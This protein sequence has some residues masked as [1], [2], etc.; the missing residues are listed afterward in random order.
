MS[1]DPMT[2]ADHS[3]L[4]SPVESPVESPVAQ[5]REIDALIAKA[6]GAHQAGQLH[7]A[8]AIYQDVLTLAPDHGDTLAFSGIIQCQM[9]NIEQGIHGLE[10][11]VAINPDHLVAQFNLAHAYESA[12]RFDAA[13]GAYRRVISLKPDLPDAHHHLAAVLDKLGKSRE[14]EQATCTALLAKPENSK[15]FYALIQRQ[16]KNGHLEDALDTCEKFFKAYPRNMHALAFKAFIL[17]ELGDIDA[18]RELL[19]FDRLIIC[20]RHHDVPGYETNK[21][22]NADLAEFALSHP[23]LEFEPGGKSTQAGS[24]TATIQDETAKP[25][26][27]LRQLIE[28][29]LDGYC[30]AFADHPAHPYLDSM[31]SQIALDIWA[32]VLRPEGQQKPH[33]HPG[34]W[35][36]GVYYPLLPAAMSSNGDTPAG[37]IEFGRP[38]DHFGFK[39]EPLI[40]SLQPEEGLMVLFPSYFYHRTIPVAEKPE[41][42]PISATEQRFSFAFDAIA[43]I[44]KKTDR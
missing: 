26:K 37:W 21:A 8:F 34:G 44:P 39:A 23:S 43:A 12:G 18:A 35:L 3:P 11:A 20:T 24:H 32:T 15:I 9:G 17:N 22:F 30:D 42:L 7:E 28:R 38:Q 4:Q 10:R 31:P 40:H 5:N 27:V 36:S 1:Q 33:F 25:I 29:A 13:A 2:P 6:L 14:A 19:D 16:V 41:K